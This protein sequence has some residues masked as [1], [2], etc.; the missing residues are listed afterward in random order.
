M[1]TPRQYQQEAFGALRNYWMSG[2]GHPL[3][4]LPTG[5]GKSVVLAMI[6][7]WARSVGV[8]IMIVT[9]VD[10]LVRQ[11]HAEL[12]GMWPQAP[13]GIYHAGIGRR[14]T[15]CPIIFAGIQSAFEKA[16]IFG[17]RQII[18]I[19]EAQLVPHGENGMY[20]Q[21]F[22]TVE[23]LEPHVRIA[24]LTATPY[25]MSTGLLTEDWKDQPAIFD[26]VIFEKPITWFIDNGYLSPLVTRGTGTKLEVT[27]ADL[28]SQK[29]TE[30]AVNHV[31]KTEAAVSEVFELGSDRRCW[32]MF[33][34]GVKHAG[35]IAE[36]VAV[37][38]KDC[39]IVTGQK[40]STGIFKA[41]GTF[42]RIDRQECV[43]AFHANQF[44]AM[45]N[46]MV[47]TTGFNVPQIDLIADM[48]PTGSPGLHVQKLG[49]AT[50]LSDGKENGLILDFAG[51]VGRHG[52]LD[53]ITGRRTPGEGVA[54]VKECPECQLIQAAGKR[55]C[56]DCGYE[57]P[58]NELRIF[59]N[60]QAAALLSTQDEARWLYISKVH[61]SAHTSR[62]TGL[63][64]LR[65]QYR[66][67]LTDNISEFVCL[68]HPP[69]NYAYK[70][71]R[72]WWRRHSGG[73]E[74]PLTTMEALGRLN[75]L[76]YPGR[77]LVQRRGK[78]HDIIDRDFATEIAA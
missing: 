33:G 51:N 26:D 69:S 22:K 21:F 53:T 36:I 71:A 56:D 12:M 9:H 30:A 4:V 43:E 37:H 18:L 1:I 35:S 78:Y 73:M 62:K 14:D 31:D 13:A 28:R 27:K 68:E 46:N 29:K 77:L 61:A 60:A 17:K 20:H 74:A 52:P 23:R 41:G 57:W 67:G 70:K 19:D 6:C 8:R 15:G 24:G 2:G 34:A 58:E 65:L 54:P 7:Q 72:E 48:A 55:K 75:E 32:L 63:M 66:C 40:N 10:Q 44:G 25:R 59:A 50:R 16:E 11:N 49:R 42:E 5:T 47:L 45:S 64:M 3:I 76:R 38:G 39:G